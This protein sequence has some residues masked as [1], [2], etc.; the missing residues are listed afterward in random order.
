MATR[1]QSL[2]EEPD[3][4]YE[5]TSVGDGDQD[6]LG[7]NRNLGLELNGM[8][9]GEDE[10]E[11]EDAGQTPTPESATLEELRKQNEQLAAQ[12]Q[13]LSG[14]F[15]GY[16]Q[17][18]AGLNELGEKIGQERGPNPQQKPGESD[19]EF[20]KRINESLYEDPYSNLEAWGQ[21]RF[22]PVV[23]Q[24]M[25][26]NLQMQRQIMRLDP[27]KGKFF[28]KYEK[29]IDRELSNLPPQMRY[30]DPEV[31]TKVYKNVVAAHVEEIVE[32]RL[33]ERMGG[34]EGQSQAPTRRQSGQAPY[35]GG[36]QTRS[37][38]GGEGANSQRKIPDY[39]REFALKR[40][41]HESDA[42]A[43]MKE[44]NMLRRAK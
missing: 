6:E 8:L 18:Q 39:V 22:G 31:L 41:M 10:G 25:D 16:Q 38:Q 19:E 21:R 34:S 24:M 26:R 3:F 28:A 29:E 11:D 14:Q 32:E 17:V 4:E 27:E 2:G 7:P 30:N 9:F 20:K 35:S 36:S 12:V 37:R 40:G 42:Y 15:N 1:D 5:D 23:Q 33:K 43:F 13:S 44:N